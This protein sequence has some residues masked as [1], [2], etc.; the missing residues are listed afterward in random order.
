M[1]KLG[2]NRKEIFK[3]FYE[4]MNNTRSITAIVAFIATFI[5]SA[6]LVRII[7]PA[8]AVEYV[9]T[10]RP[11]YTN[12]NSSEIE[13][14]LLRDIRNGENRMNRISSLRENERY[15]AE[16]A[17]AVMNYSISSSNMDASRFPQDF[18][19]AWREHMKAWR[20]YAEFLKE[21]DPTSSKCSEGRL[22]AE[23]N[24]TW[25]EVVRIGRSYGA[26]VE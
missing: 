19:N 14:F 13:S 10:N 24:R 12:R 7:F 2:H 8:P 20:N 1:K 23:I 17:D 22:N 3:R 11:Q 18:Q 25:I 6:G 16:F 15:S 9:F 5:F 26:D 21:A 4:F